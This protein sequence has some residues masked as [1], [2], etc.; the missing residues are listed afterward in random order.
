[1]Q[2][3]TVILV[4][5]H[6][7]LCA[8]GASY[9][10]A[11]DN[12]RVSFA[13]NSESF[14]AS[15]VQE[16]L[17]Q[18]EHADETTEQDTKEE[19]VIKDQ[20][21]KPESMSSSTDS[22]SDET[23]PASEA[24]ST[25]AASTEIASTLTIEKKKPRKLIEEENRAVGRIGRDIWEW[26]FS[27]VGGWM[28]WVVFVLSVALGALG[29]VAENGWLGYVTNIFNIVCIDSGYLAIGQA[30]VYAKKKKKALRST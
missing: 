9:I 28:Y 25:S 15:G 24:S 13:G 12:G 10:V 5:H 21:S 22:P 11:L 8:P 6:I 16:T 23:S 14:K 19:K 3:R 2:G 27:A 29:P 4:S 1:M 7:Q 17:M 18:S 20:F 26:Y 30:Q